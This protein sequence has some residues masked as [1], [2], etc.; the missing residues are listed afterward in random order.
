M[1][2]LYTTVFDYILNRWGQKQG[3]NPIVKATAANIIAALISARNS[4]TAFINKCPCVS[5]LTASSKELKKLNES[6]KN[7]SCTR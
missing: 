6:F 2:L 1:E 7:G 3:Q 5:G 4:T